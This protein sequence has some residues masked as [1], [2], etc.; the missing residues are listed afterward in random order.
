[1]SG[2][3]DDKS[4]A[5]GA[6][7]P[8]S[9]AAALAAHRAGDLAAAERAYRAHLDAHPND[10][11]ALHMLG[12]LRQQQGHPHESA[13]LIERALAAG[14]QGALPQANL[15]AVRLA[16]GESARAAS[17]ARAAL[18]L[19]REHFGAWLNLGL[20]CERLG[21]LAGARAALTEARARRPDDTRTSLALGRVLE[22]SGDLPAA[23]EMLM[24]AV[25]RAPNDAEA[26]FLLGRAQYRSGALSAAIATLERATGLAGAPRD[27]WLI[28]ASAQLDRGEPEASIATSDAL[29][30]RWPDYAEAASNRLIAL[31]HLPG[32]DCASLDHAHRDWAQRHARVARVQHAIPTSNPERRLRIG[33]LSPRFLAGPVPT[34]LLP[35]LAARDRSQFEV[36]LFMASSYRDAETERLRSA[37]ERWHEV[38]ALDDPA[39]AELMREREID[40]AVDL[41]G[42]AP[43][44]RLT[45][46]ALGLAPLQ[47]VWLDYFCSTG[48]D[49]FD[50]FLSDAMLTPP[51]S[52]Q[53]YT[54]A[55]LI[56]LAAGRLC[57]APPP[58]APSIHP[59]S[60]AAVRF[61]SFNRLAKLNAD[62]ARTWAAILAAVPDSVLRLRGTAFADSTTRDFVLRER[63]APHGIGADRI[64]FD[65]W[66][67]H[68]ET[69]AAYHE[70]DIALDPFPFSGC[71]TSC[72]ALWMGVPVVT[73]AGETLVSRQSASLLAAAGLEPL[74]TGSVDDYIAAAIALARDPQHR[75]ELRSELR[76][77]ARRGFGDSTRFATAFEAAIR[78]LWKKAGSEYSYRCSR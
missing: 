42:H 8:A 39:L 13:T 74:I 34:F 35:Y 6:L 63:F 50:A 11:D 78:E 3:T 31:Q 10:A 29:L 77:R 41:S 56:R 19:D 16:L 75:A 66:G 70:I 69:L 14:A 68:L 36:E 7:S 60:A 47:V 28:L 49:C 48:L 44:N 24:L 65:G 52:P 64:E 46:F 62:V 4:S 9:L 73:L 76:Q 40:I 27:A 59:R 22:V 58:G 37:C 55:A 18:A 38:A 67:S 43:G 33:M 53:R 45:A 57:Y 54:E 5:R 20:A 32:I 25:A 26:A 21:D 30:A 12:L 17:A 71:A 1:L 51:S 72:D 15:S 23:V 61:A 2:T